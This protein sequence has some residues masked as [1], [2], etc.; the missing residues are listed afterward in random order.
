[1]Y[2]MFDEMMMFEMESTIH[3]SCWVG[4]TSFGFLLA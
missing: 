3:N 1:M 2:V 4:G